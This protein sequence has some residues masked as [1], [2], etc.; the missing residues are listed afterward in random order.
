MSV[1]IEI[2]KE[3][4]E[5]LQKAVSFYKQGKF[6]EESKLVSV[7]NGL[8]YPIGCYSC[9]HRIEEKTYKIEDEGEKLMFHKKCIDSLAKQNRYL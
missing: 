8:G 4:N 6:E 5:T 1:K 9:L 7:V 2:G 3:Y